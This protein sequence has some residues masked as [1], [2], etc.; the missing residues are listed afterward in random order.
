V[1]ARQGGSR[2]SGG[3]YATY[4]SNRSANGVAS[5]VLVQTVNT[6]ADVRRRCSSRRP[7]TRRRRTRRGSHAGARTQRQLRRTVFAVSGGRERDTSLARLRGWLARITGAEVTQILDRDAWVGWSAGTLRA[8]LLPFTGG[9][10]RA[11][12]TKSGVR[13]A[14]TD[15]IRPIAQPLVIMSSMSGRSSHESASV[16]SASHAGSLITRYVS[17]VARTRREW[18][19]RVSP[20]IS[21]PRSIKTSNLVPSVRSPRTMR[22]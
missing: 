8:I 6:R 15:Q 3:R 10:R 22:Q 9:R 1:S 21:I 20:N 17:R 13:A 2:K 14:L 5:H 18:P 11:S 4:V 19:M 16:A 7:A 12:T